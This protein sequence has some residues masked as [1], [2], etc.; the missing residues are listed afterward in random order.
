MTYPRPQ[1]VRN[2]WLGLNGTWR[3]RTGSQSAAEG[4]EWETI[5]VPFCPESRMSGICRRIA[6]GEKMIYERDFAVPEE[7]SGSRIILHFGAVDQTAQVFVDGAEAGSHEGGYLPFSMDIT[8]FLAEDEDGRH[9]LRVEAVDD[10]DHRYPWGKQK[11]NNGGMWYTPVSGI[12]QS[13][14]MEP[15]PDEHI[16]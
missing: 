12:W 14:W 10:L 8:E 3:F 16:T 6:P 13:V 4:G 2:D 1:L 11:R 7:W 5:N 9:V 15:V